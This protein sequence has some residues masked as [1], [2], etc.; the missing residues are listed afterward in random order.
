MNPRVRQRS[1]GAAARQD[2][3]PP[4]RMGPPA[5]DLREVA[6]P[7]PAAVAPL[8][9]PPPRAVVARASA[10]GESAYASALLAAQA[11]TPALPEPLAWAVLT[12]AEMV[13]RNTAG[14]GDA[15]A[16]IDTPDDLLIAVQML[17]D[18]GRHRLPIGAQ[19]AQLAVNAFAEAWLQGKAELPLCAELDADNSDAPRPPPFSLRYIVRCF[20]E[21]LPPAEPTAADPPPP[22]PPPDGVPVFTLAPSLLGRYRQLGSCN[23]MLHAKTEFSK[24]HNVGDGGGGGRRAA[25]TATLLKDGSATEAVLQKGMY[26]EA[27]LTELIG[28][29]APP[30]CLAPPLRPLPKAT[31]VRDLALEAFRA[32]VNR[33]TGSCACGHTEETRLGADLREKRHANPDCAYSHALL[34]I[35]KEALLTEVSTPEEAV[36]LYQAKFE[37]PSKLYEACGVDTDVLRFTNFQPD[38]VYVL[39]GEAPGTRELA[40]VDAKASAHV[41]VAHRVQVAAYAWALDGLIEEGV[42]EGRVTAPSR[43]ADV[44]AIWRPGCAAPDVFA[45][46]EPKRQHVEALKGPLSKSVLTRA[47]YAL[48][49]EQSLKEPSSLAYGQDWQLRSSCASCEFLTQCRKEAVN[50]RKLASVPGMGPAAVTALRELAELGDIEDVPAQRLADWLRESGTPA[51]VKAATKEPKMRRAVAALA[52]LA[53]AAL[54]DALPEA[55]LHER[56]QRAAQSDSSSA[57]AFSPRLAAALEDRV[58][59]RPGSICTALPAPQPAGGKLEDIVCVSLLSDPTTGEA[60]AWAVQTFT[61]QPGQSLLCGSALAPAVAVVPRKQFDAAAAYAPPPPPDELERLAKDAAAEASSSSDGITLSRGLALRRGLVAELHAAL[62]GPDTRLACAVML[63][64]GERAAV[65]RMLFDVATSGLAAEA[66]LRVPAQCCLFACLDARLLAAEN[67]VGMDALAEQAGGVWSNNPADGWPRF[68]Q[69]HKSDSPSMAAL[70]PALPTLLELPALGFFTLADVAR[71]VAA[72]APALQALPGG[73]IDALRDFILGPEAELGRSDSLEATVAALDGDAAYRDWGARAVGGEFRVAELVARR[74]RLAA[75]TLDGLRALLD[76]AGGPSGAANFLPLSAAVRGAA[77][78][79]QPFDSAA[80]AR[81]ALFKCM[82]LRAGGAAN[83]AERARPLA[84]RL[85]K[86]KTLLVRVTQAP[87]MR[88]DGCTITVQLVPELAGGAP[89]STAEKLLGDLKFKQWLLV[90]LTRDGLLSTLRFPESALAHVGGYIGR[91]LWDAFPPEERRLRA[92]L[93][94]GALGS[95]DLTPGQAPGALNLRLT[96]GPKDGGRY[97]ALNPSSDCAAGTQLLLCLRETDT[98]GPRVAT[99]A[100]AMVDCP[101]GGP[102]AWLHSLM[103][104]NEIIVS[105]VT[106][107]SGARLGDCVALFMEWDAHDRKF[108]KVQVTASSTVCMKEAVEVRVPESHI[109]HKF[110][111]YRTLFDPGAERGVMLPPFDPAVISP[112]GAWA[113]GLDCKLLKPMV[114]H[115]AADPLVA[116]LATYARQSTPTASQRESFERVVRHR[117]SA[118]WG[119]PGAGK[120]HFSAGMLLALFAAYTEAKVPLRVLVCAATKAATRVLLRK[121]SDEADLLIKAGQLQPGHIRLFTTEKDGLP[122]DEPEPPVAVELAPSAAALWDI[123]R[124]V[125]GS[126]VWQASKL[127]SAMQTKEGAPPA[128]KFDLILVDEASQLLACDA[129]LVVDLLDPFSGRLVVVGDHLQMPPVIRGTGYPAGTAG[130]PSPAASL[131][132]AVRGALKAGGPKAAEHAT[133]CTLLDNHR[134]APALAQFCA[135]PEGIYPAGFR[136]CSE[137]GCPCR[138]LGRERKLPLRADAEALCGAGWLGRAL[139][140]EAQLV[141]IRLPGADDKEEARVA[142]ALMKRASECWAV[143]EKFCSDAFVVAPH[144]RQIASL[145]GELAHL[146]HLAKGL[147]SISTVETVQ[148]READLVVVLYALSD[149]DAIAAEADFLYGLERLNV[150]LTRARQKAV[151]LLTRAV[152]SP[153]ARAAAAAASP[154]ADEGLAFLRRAASFARRRGWY[155]KLRRRDD[156]SETEDGADGGFEVDESP[157]SDD[158]GGTAERP[159]AWPGNPMVS[160]PRRLHAAP[161]DDGEDADAL[162]D[163]DMPVSDEGDEMD[164][165]APESQ[166]AHEAA[167]EELSGRLMAQSSNDDGVASAPPAAAPPQPPPLSQGGDDAG[168]PDHMAWALPSQPAV[169]AFSGDVSQSRSFPPPSSSESPSQDGGYGAGAAAAPQRDVV[170]DT[171]GAPGSQS[172]PPFVRPG[173]FQGPSWSAPPKTTAPPESADFSPLAPQPAAPHTDGYQQRSRPGPAAAG[174][175]GLASQRGPIMFDDAQAGPSRDAPVASPKDEIESDS[176]DG[177]QYMYAQ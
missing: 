4:G 76:A 168:G 143:K 44:G 165:V 45:L 146:A 170:P 57:C 12:L 155:I 43:V 77:L 10:S 96:L 139:N 134:M 31:R 78:Q 175:T 109:C 46:E 35:S 115:P 131:L 83:R 89:D 67:A 151:L 127:Y 71:H 97:S 20:A 105:D 1:E 7:P 39:P 59:V 152:A 34:E 167:V 116:V 11:A 95:S 81:S 135:A 40:I 72:A 111:L 171:Y 73:A 19:L 103:P 93:H 55:P 58:R 63:D 133:S 24:R 16:P 113:C 107:R 90:P 53:P 166:P 123:E 157:D 145:T 156:D 149:P 114:S 32:A 21:R 74:C 140:P 36:C 33:S 66:D 69:I 15:P 82:E 13:M 2:T 150:A 138:H 14:R 162:A 153:D 26:F 51:V 9:A 147:L 117:L 18:M 75:A 160:E 17:A 173:A 52:A 124:C 112:A 30:A 177:E 49:Y 108:A 25:R 125:V 27:A 136:E 126:T 161:S 118:V 41:K 84:A 141:V 174:A 28:R 87:V 92:S 61:V 29:E 86:D 102:A 56:V 120:T 70:L 68:R 169:E 88:S 62:C 106:L 122:A 128:P 48:A 3:A 42:Q 50:P 98:L 99:Y 132:E 142:A 144:H 176:E 172:S 163:E 64:G 154:A 110:S 119:P 79:V 6:P 91:N 121:L 37:V 5:A 159:P 54:A 104:N 148:G 80:C 38:Y 101:R 100:R 8:A 130:C 158:E 85:R 65:L 60:Y 22:L 47:A 23:R 129:M 94:L 137:T 164:G